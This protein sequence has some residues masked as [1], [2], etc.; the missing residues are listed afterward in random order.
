MSDG[1]VR[2]DVYVEQGS[3]TGEAGR[4]G[5]KE[6]ANWKVVQGSGLLSLI[7]ASRYVLARLLADPRLPS[8][9]AAEV[10]VGAVS[11]I[12][13]E[14]AARGDKFMKELDFVLANQDSTRLI[15]C[16]SAHTH[17]L[18]PTL[19][20][21]VLIILTNMALVLALSP[22]A[23][24]AAPP[25]AGTFGA[26]M[27]GLPSYFLQSGDFSAAQR[28]V[29]LFSKARRAPFGTQGVR[30]V[31]RQLAIFLPCTLALHN[32]RPSLASSALAPRL[33]ASSSPRA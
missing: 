16:P 7:A 19:L 20:A 17:T 18:A 29:C 23:Q 4:I 21:Q 8:V 32:R 28:A 11:L 30:G 2:D 14:K 10:A 27:A 33:P 31:R 12:L 25:P 24:L 3:Y 5:A 6:L 1:R 13:A 9:L 26:Y 22:A 15:P